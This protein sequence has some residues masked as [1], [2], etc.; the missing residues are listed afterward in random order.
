MSYHNMLQ[1]LPT[2]L[3]HLDSPSQTS[4]S[5]VHFPS[6]VHVRF[7]VTLVI[8]HV[9]VT[10]SPTLYDDLITEALIP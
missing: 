7:C 5:G 3:L 9:Y 2:I 8:I 10:V 1:T 4:V 6:D